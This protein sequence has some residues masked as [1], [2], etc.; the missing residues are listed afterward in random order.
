VLG[1]GGTAR[2]A[3]VAAGELGARRVTVVARDPAKA[4]PLLA[5]AAAVGAD[6]RVLTF[7]DP[8]LADAVTAAGAVVSTIPADA[9]ARHLD[10]LRGA[11]VLLDAIY[12]PWPT[13][14]AAAV[15]EAGGSVIDGLQMLL[16]QA[17]VQV[18][19]FTG[20]PAP[21]EA[22]RAALSGP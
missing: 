7:S 12:D 9:A 13:P 19:L 5:L 14:L 18:E 16:H 15:L 17:F 8:G 20:R 4:E 2:A 21:Q 1:A 22:M 3:V 11:A 10:A 6:G